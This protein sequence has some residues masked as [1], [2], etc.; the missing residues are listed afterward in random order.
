MDAD[1]PIIK[2]T[3]EEKIRIMRLW[4]RTLIIKLLG[5]NIG[6]NL[7]Y[8]KIHELWKP[9][10]SVDLVSIDNGFFSIRFSSEEDY[11]FTKYKGPW[12]IFNHYLTVSSG[13]SRNFE[14]GGEFA[15]KLIFFLKIYQYIE[16][17]YEQLY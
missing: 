13:G 5:R 1:C 17:K 11:E 15:N 10:A 4:R 12:M 7:L 6:Y 16:I 3:K 14:R 2:M 9:K 8:R